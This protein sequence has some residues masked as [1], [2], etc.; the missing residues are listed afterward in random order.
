MTS[1][2]PRKVLLV[3]P[4][5]PPYGGLSVQLQQWQ[6]YVQQTHGWTCEVLNI[7]DRREE[8]LPGAHPVRGYLD[9]WKKLTKYARQGYL[10]HLFTNGHN[11]KSWLSALACA[12]AGCI[13]HRRSLLVFGSGNLPRFIIQE[14]GPLARAV[15]KTAVRL[16]GQIVC[17]NNDMLEALLKLGVN[18]SKVSIVSGYYG[19]FDQSDDVPGDIQKFLTEHQ[20]VLGAM[21]TTLSPEYGIPLFLDAVERLHHEYPGLGVVLMGIGEK[22]RAQVHIPDQLDVCLAGALPNPVAMAVMNR[23]SVFV[24]PSLFDGDS[25]SV[26][27]ALSLGIPVVASDTG[28]RPA[29]VKLFAKGDAAQMTAAVRETIEGAETVVPPTTTSAR[30]ESVTQLLS[31]Y[32]KLVPAA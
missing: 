15:A 14:S 32:E 22:E 2:P 11:L 7:G 8:P 29:G 20:P 18:H 9:F 5:P 26:R 24:R 27:E 13:N 1:M 3:G 21:A 17:R 4:Y 28:L 6:R 12:L 31:L 10:I 19:T 30:E 23:L 16:S 25:R